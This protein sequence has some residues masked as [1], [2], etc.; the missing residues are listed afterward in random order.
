[1]QTL[2]TFRTQ[3]VRHRSRRARMWNM[4]LLFLIY[5]CVSIYSAKG[6]EK[7]EIP[8]DV[9]MLP[10]APDADI[11]TENEGSTPFPFVTSEVSAL[12]NP[13]RQ[14]TIYSSSSS[15]IGKRCTA[16]YNTGHAYTWRSAHLA[17]QTHQLHAASHRTISGTADE[18]MGATTRRPRSAH[19]GGD[20]HLLRP[21]HCVRRV[22]CGQSG[23]V[24]RG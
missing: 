19:P 5:Y 2:Y 7:A 12:G 13:I 8:P 21:G 3:I 16:R 18:Q 10:E 24:V 15:A 9:G 1:M 6:D 14:Y 17:T 11:P 22:L 20:I 23:Q 4:G